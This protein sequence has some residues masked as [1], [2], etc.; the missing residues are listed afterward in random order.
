VSCVSLEFENHPMIKTENAIML[1]ML[2]TKFTN[3]ISLSLGHMITAQL[4]E[5][6][7]RFSFST[8]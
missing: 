3:S 6:P 5:Y 4:S 1:A 2:P 8:K 7:P